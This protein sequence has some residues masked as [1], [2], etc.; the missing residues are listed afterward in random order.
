MINRHW[1]PEYLA[2]LLHSLATSPLKL[3]LQLSF[4]NLLRYRRRNS[5]LLAS[6]VVSLIGIIF[7]SAL[8]R[9]WEQDLVRGSVEDFSG[10]VKMLHPRFLADPTTAHH[11]TLLDLDASIYENLE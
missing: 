3:V 9:G 5:F 8:I 6:I 1:I 4:R 2:G 7:S 10:H 11:F